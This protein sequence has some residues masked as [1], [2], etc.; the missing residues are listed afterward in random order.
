MR[1]TAGNPGSAAP[2]GRPPAPPASHARTAPSFPVFQRRP[3]L[4]RGASAPSTA[5]TRTR[6]D[7]APAVTG[8]LRMRGG[9]TGGCP[10]AGLTVSD[11]HGAG[12]RP[13]PAAD[14][15][16]PPG[17]SSG[18]WPTCARWSGRARR[19][20]PLFADGRP[21]RVAARL[22]C[23]AISGD[24]SP[25]GC[26]PRCRC[27]SC[28]AAAASACVRGAGGQMSGRAPGQWR[29]SLKNREG[30]CCPRVARRGLAGACPR[31][32]HR[33][34]SRLWSSSSLGP[35]RGPGA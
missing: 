19:G 27:V 29:P 6:A 22:A 35:S 17:T 1:T 28:A 4:T 2:A 21:R 18:A 9:R 11:S 15:G 14:R 33:R 25:P 12:G 16:S 5:R 8:H 30:R 32:R 31:V 13:G 34:G 26:G 3:P 24:G 20:L 23:T 7:A 10:G